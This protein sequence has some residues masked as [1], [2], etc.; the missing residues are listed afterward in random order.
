MDAYVVI[1]TKGRPTEVLAL[2]DSLSK[3]TKRASEVLIVGSEQGD[4][5]GLAGHTFAQSGICKAMIASSAG[6]TAQRN[7]GVCRLTSQGAFDLSAA[8]SFCAFF[9]DDYRPAPDWLERADERLSRGDVVGLTGKMLAD[10]INIGGLREEQAQAF[11]NGRSA[12]LPHWASG[13]AEWETGSVYGC[14]MAFTDIVIRQTRFDECLPLYGWQED[15]D[16]TGLA[17]RLGRVIYFPGCQGVHLGV[18]NGRTSGLRFGYSQIANPLYLMRKGTMDARSG[19][20]FMG[21]ALAANL[22]RSIRKHPWV[23]YRG[24][25]KGNLIALADMLRW[26]SDPRHILDLR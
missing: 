23:D 2:I 18:T 3:Q 1:A 21:R 9:D 6:L 7:A 17:R 25:L 10:G 4:I 19:A 11:L 8:R 26:R 20:R 12:P 5:S 22:V 15:R 16:Y 24:R 13:E 14:N